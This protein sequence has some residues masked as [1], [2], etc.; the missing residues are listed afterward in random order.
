MKNL[1]IYTIYI[2]TILTLCS[3]YA[4]QPIQPLFESEFNLSRFEAVV[5]TTVIMLPLG[6]APILYGFLLETISS[7]KVLI[8]AIFALGVSEIIFASSDTYFLL[9]SLRGFQGLLI[10]AILTSLMSYISQTISQDRV[11]QAMGFYIG[12]TIVGGFAGRFFSGLL[13]DVFGW[14]F[15]FVFL[16]IMLIINSLFLRKI[17]QDIKTNYAKPNLTKI[18][19]VLKIPHNLYI[20]LSMFCAFFVFQGLLNF[21]PFELKNIAGD[22][23]GS[24]VGLVYA[25]YSI[26]VLISFNALKI[27]KIFKN[28]TNAMLFGIIVYLISLQLFRYESYQIMFASMFVF[29]AGA[30]IVHSIASGFVNKLSTKYKAISNGL[31]ISFYYSGGTLGSFIPGVVYENFGWQWFLSSLSLVI[32]IAFF[33]LLVLH[34][35]LQNKINQS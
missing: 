33:M 2:C 10:P 13:S 25:G 28:E 31:Y 24:K 35:H 14:R 4:A 29:C 7:K 34:K 1:Q 8:G 32:L 20:Y 22:F 11:Q 3:L 6:I 27:I 26:G 9:I 18:T 16:G 15:F 12:I 23:S 17:S 30:F 5:F 21:I 19:N